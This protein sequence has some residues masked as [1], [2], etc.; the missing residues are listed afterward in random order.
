MRFIDVGQHANGFIAIGQEANG[1]IAI[2]QVATGVVAI[3]QLARGV[4]VLGQLAIGVVSVGMVSGGLVYCIGMLGAGGRSGPSMLVLPLVPVLPKPAAPPPH[5]TLADIP[6]TGPGW[7][8]ANVVVQGQG[9]QI[10][11]HQGDVPIALEPALAAAMRARAISGRTLLWLE[12]APSA[13]ASAFRSAAGALVAKR[14]MPYP[15]TLAQFLSPGRLVLS[16]LQL[17]GLAILAAV[18]VEV[19]LTPL[20]EM[21]IRLAPT[22]FEFG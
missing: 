15:A 12:S 14:A 7:V 5:K 18:Y 20:I 9:E 19:A 6:R 13:A 1:V 16:A 21:L 4:F 2:G 11:A 22:F 17:L 3:G 10:S 8:D